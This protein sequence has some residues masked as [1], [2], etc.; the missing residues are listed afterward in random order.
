MLEGRAGSW[1]YLCESATQAEKEKRCRRLS[2][3][4]ATYR[5]TILR[6]LSVSRLLPRLVYDGV[7]SVWE[8][9]DILS[10][11]GHP[12]RVESFLL[13]L[14]S[15]G[16]KAFCA[17][18]SHLEAFCP[19]LLTCFFL[20]YQERTHRIVQDASAAEAEARLGVRP[21]PGDALE[22]EGQEQIPRL[23]NRVTPSSENPHGA[24]SGVSQGKPSLRRIKGRLHRSK[25]LDSIDFCELT[26]DV[27]AALEGRRFGLEVRSGRCREQPRE[28]P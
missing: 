2:E 3:M 1:F 21:E 26:A 28:L 18:C 5:E 17:F 12:Q 11:D 19:Y 13:K 10:R 8:Y 16:P 25:S 15:K 22:P 24:T 9:R 27:L 14:C 4:P 23:S 7:F 6:D 20:Y